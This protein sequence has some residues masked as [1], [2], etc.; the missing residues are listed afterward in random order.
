MSPLTT[1]K[2]HV[3][4]TIWRLWSS[5]D[6]G[7]EIQIGAGIAVLDRREFQNSTREIERE[8]WRSVMAERATGIIPKR[9]NR[10]LSRSTPRGLGAHPFTSL[11]RL[12]DEVDRMF[13]DFAFGW[14][15][16]GLASWSGAESGMWTPEVEAF[17]RGDQLVIRADLPGLT[18]DDLTIDVTEDAVTIRGER[19]HEHKDEREGYYRSERSY[20]SFYRV[21]PLPS[22]AI[23]EQ[24]K[25]TFRDGVLEVTMPTPPSSTARRLEIGEGSKT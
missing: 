17:Q 10:E 1:H 15:S 21:I 3:A 4:F 12:A 19:K 20:G 13:D 11:R 8:V 24:A 25:A 9:E 14:R 2:V 22:G 23:T 16:P 6:R 5:E 18:K 7:G